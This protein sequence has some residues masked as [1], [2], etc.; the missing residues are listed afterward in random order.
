MSEQAEEG[1]KGVD[2]PPKAIVAALLALGLA[3]F[4]GQNTDD[5]TVRWL[6]FERESPLWMALVAAMAVAFV[7]G[8]L[9][10]RPRRAKR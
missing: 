6:V 8:V 1:K 10:G 7:I 3:A 4:V 5:V 9:V 2:I